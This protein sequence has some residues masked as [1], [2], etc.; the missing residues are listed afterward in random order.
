MEAEDQSLLFLDHYELMISEA[1]PRQ[2]FSGYNCGLLVLSLQFLESP[3]YIPPQVL[4]TLCA[5]SAGFLSVG[6]S[7]WSGFIC[8][9][10]RWLSRPLGCSRPG[11]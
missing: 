6:S 9:S 8:L 11:R 2:S 4:S 5:R 3:E 1:L 7:V 10:D